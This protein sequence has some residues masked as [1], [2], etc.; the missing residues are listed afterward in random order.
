M[1]IDLVSVGQGLDFSQ[2]AAHICDAHSMKGGT[3]FDGA[4]GD[5]IGVA[6]RAGGGT[7]AICIKIFRR[8]GIPA[9][10]LIKCAIGVLIAIFT[11]Q[12]AQGGVDDLLGFVD[13][14][15]FCIA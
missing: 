13:F 14:L 5:H 2:R 7:N 3:V 1:Q 4:A 11:S 9:R 10:S 12:V 15:N 8:V 6:I